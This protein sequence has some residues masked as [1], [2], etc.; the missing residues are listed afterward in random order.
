MFRFIRDNGEK[1]AFEYEDEYTL[2]RSGKI[3]RSCPP[4]LGEEARTVLSEAFYAIAEQL[5][6]DAE[7]LRRRGKA[8]DDDE[9]FGAMVSG[10]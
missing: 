7:E 2:G 4:V 6:H 1:R 5:E 8:I 3:R 10:S 9:A